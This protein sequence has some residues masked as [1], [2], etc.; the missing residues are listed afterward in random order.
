MYPVC[1]KEHQRFA[2]NRGALRSRAVGSIACYAALRILRQRF[3]PIERFVFTR[4]LPHS[5]KLPLMKRRP[6][7]HQPHRTGGQVPRDHSQAVDGDPL[8]SISALRS[9]RS[10]VRGGVVLEP[11]TAPLPANPE[12]LL[13]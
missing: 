6:F 8:A 12:P 10:I 5:L 2:M 4:P 7:G 9:P 3:K 11:M 1:T 13:R